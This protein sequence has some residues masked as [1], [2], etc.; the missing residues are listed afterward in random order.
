[1]A[2]FRSRWGDYGAAAVNGNSVW[3]A[4]EYIAHT[5]DYTDWYPGRACA[6][7]HAA[8]TA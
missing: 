3:I 8:G 5:C 7:E 6:D 2:Q 4:S 1:L